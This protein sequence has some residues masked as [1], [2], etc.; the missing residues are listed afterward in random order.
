MQKGDAPA[1]PLRQ[2]R[3]C[4]RRSWSRTEASACSACIALLR[5]RW[6]LFCAAVPRSRDAP[7]PGRLPE[8][9]CTPQ[10]YRRLVLQIAVTGSK[11]ADYTE[12]EVINYARAHPRHRHS[13]KP[14][15]PCNLCYSNLLLP[16]PRHSHP[17]G[18]TNCRHC[19]SSSPATWIVVRSPY[20]GPTICTPI[21]NPAWVTPIGATLAGR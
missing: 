21:G 11:A 6:I 16:P 2:H 15:P 8:I 7:L 18:A 13:T 1:T 19:C 12:S 14:S 4:D 9:R 10:W 20:S 3:M 5:L 17:G